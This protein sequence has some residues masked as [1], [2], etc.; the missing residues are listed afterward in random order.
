MA[1]DGRELWRFQ[2]GAP[3]ESSPSIGG[4]TL[5]VGSNDGHLYALDLETG[6]ER[7]RFKTGGP[8]RSSPWVGDGVVFIGS[9][10]G[11]I[12]AIR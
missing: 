1:D 8:V 2:T 4:K 9:D 12:Y 5:Y 10:D 11:R 6:A 3:V 7:A